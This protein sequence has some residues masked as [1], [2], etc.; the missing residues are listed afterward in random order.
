MYA[1]WLLPE[2][3]DAFYLSKIINDLSK[4]YRAPTFFPHITIYGLVDVS[5]EK[6]N[7]S[8]KKSIEEINTIIVKAEKVDFSDNLWKTIF[9]EIKNNNEMNLIYKRLSQQLMTFGDYNFFPHISLIYKKLDK[10]E[11]LDIIK[12]LKIKNEFVIEKIAILNDSKNIEEWKIE[13]YFTLK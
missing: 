7:Q 12:N 10:S 8:I 2:K 11:K 4:K 13:N 5:L 1:I 6:L 9:I 3:K